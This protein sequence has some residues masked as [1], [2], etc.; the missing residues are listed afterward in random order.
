M[1]GMTTD[2]SAAISDYRGRS[3]IIRVTGLARQDMMKTS[4]YEVKVPFSQMSQTI[5]NIGRLGGKVSQVTI[6]GAGQS[7]PVT[8][9]GSPAE[10]ASSDEHRGEGFG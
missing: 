7:F 2:G 8:A 9:P 10:E 5:R 1:S 3:V 4:N 6:A